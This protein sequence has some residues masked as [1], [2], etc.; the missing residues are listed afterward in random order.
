MKPQEYTWTREGQE[1]FARCWTPAEVKGVICIA[2]G[3]AEHSARY[4]H[5]A[6]FFGA[7]GFATLALDHIGHGMSGGKRGYTPSYDFLL[8]SIS[9]VL[10]EAG[11]R[12]P[13]RPVFLWGHSM[14]GNLVLNYLLRRNPKEICGAIA[15]GPLL[16]LGFDPPAVK[17]F[18]AK[19]MRH[20]YPAFVE[21]A[22]LDT[23]RLARD[24]EVVKAY[25]SD[26]LV[27]NDMTVSLFFPLFE[28]GLWAIEHAGNLQQQVLLYH[29][30]EDK[31]TSPEGTEA[32]AEKAPPAKVTFKLWP[33]YFHELHNEPGKDKEAVMEGMHKWM[34]ER[35]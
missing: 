29:G 4:R 33:G 12:F 19:L 27:H 13:G 26:P 15:T 17:I 31:L 20:I 10:A 14:G 34:E 23:S 11:K 16:K 1:L 24:P 9:D 30:S 8:D 6:H 5:V 35:M 7:R 32:F 2:H 3:F 22:N 21:K 28:N 25:T 18:L